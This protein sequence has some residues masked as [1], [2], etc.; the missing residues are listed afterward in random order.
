MRLLSGR[1]ATA[2]SPLLPALSP[3]SN[4]P[5]P[6][7]RPRPPVLSTAPAT[8]VLLHWASPSSAVLEPPTAPITLSLHPL[9]TLSLHSPTT[10]PSKRRGQPTQQ[11]PQLADANRATTRCPLLCAVALCAARRHSQLLR[12]PS[13]RL[14][15]ARLPGPKCATCATACYKCQS[16]AKC[17]VPL[18]PSLCPSL[19]LS[20]P[21]ANL[22]PDTSETCQVGAPN[23][24]SRPAARCCNADHEMKCWNQMLAATEDTDVMHLDLDLDLDLDQDLDL[25]KPSNKARPVRSS[26]LVPLAYTPHHTTPHRDTQLERRHQSKHISSCDIVCLYQA[27]PSISAQHTIANTNNTTPNTS[28]AGTRRFALVSSNELRTVRPAH[29]LHS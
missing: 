26:S 13:A 15:S 20:P 16:A 9:S 17:D 19:P 23:Q 22:A 29:C 1:C 10:G 25:K 5:W 27:R 28:T 18:C 8:G 3:L 6:I 4:S 24:E 7:P 21:S 2:L 14:P 11:M 12:L